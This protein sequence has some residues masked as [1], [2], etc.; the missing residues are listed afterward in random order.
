MGVR[1]KEGTVTRRCQRQSLQAV[2]TSNITKNGFKFE[3]L[4]NQSKEVTMLCYETHLVR[5][6]HVSVK[7]LGSPRLNPHSPSSYFC[8]SV[9]YL[10]ALS[11]SFLT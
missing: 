4:G 11:L 3:L 6:K 5:R 8:G 9:P 10:I 1:E 2:S 7:D